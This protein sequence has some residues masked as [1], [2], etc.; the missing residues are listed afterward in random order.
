MTLM[1][2]NTNK[3]LQILGM[4]AAIGVV[5]I[6]LFSSNIPEGMFEDPNTGKPMLLGPIAIEELQQDPFGEWYQ[7]ESEGYEVDTELTSAIDNP[8]QYSYEVFL[9]TWCGDSRREVPRMEKILSEMG[10]DIAMVSIITVDRDKVSPN[11]E[12]EGKDIRYVP[13]LIVSKDNQEIGRIVESPSSQ[14]ATL[15][16][17]LFEITLGIAPTPNYS[18]GEY[19]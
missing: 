19:K 18:A 16:S 4:A 9:G 10:V 14:T 2:N 7:I 8:S 1:K 12:Q 17:D 3:A 11:G 6:S 5:Y 15:E 13:T